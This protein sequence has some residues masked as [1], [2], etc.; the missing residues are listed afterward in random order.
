MVKKRIWEETDESVERP[1]KKP[2]VRRLS[3]AS[4]NKKQIRKRKRPSV[5]LESLSDEKSPLKEVCPVISDQKKQKKSKRKEKKNKTACHVDLVFQKA[6]GVEHK[7][8]ICEV[9]NDGSN[10]FRAF[11]HQIYG[12]QGL[13]GL[14]RDK[15]CRYLEIHKERFVSI[16]HTEE[17]A[18]DFSCYLNRM[19]TLQTRGTEVEILALSELYKRPVELYEGQTSPRIITSGFVV[20]E[21]I[22]PPIRIS[23]SDPN[24]YYSVVA[25]DHGKT[26]MISDVAGIFEAS[27]LFQHAM[28]VEHNFQICKVPDDGN[29]LFSS[30][31][32]QVYGDASLHEIIRKKCCDFLEIHSERFKVFVVTGVNCI[33]FSHYLHTMRKLRIWGGNLEITALSEL[34]QRRVEIYA[35]ETTPRITFSDSVDYDND[36]PPIRVSFKNG[37]HY[38]SVVAENH[39]ETTLNSQ[40]VG[41]FEDAVI[42]SLS[43]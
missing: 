31:A 27:A 4:S 17:S 3:R 6:M 35:Q 32:H 19:R 9:V 29:C 1:F 39:N 22:R 13:H 30:F 18:F 28:K 10:L 43:N 5:I 14:I 37:N 20:Y 42:A 34:Y 41:E 12:D 21:N 7:L 38:N 36:F 33:D 25:K 2:S 15:C 16:I 23:L 40:Q 8:G 26:T 24:L 11:S